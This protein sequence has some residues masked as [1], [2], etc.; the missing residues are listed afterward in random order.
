VC[1]VGPRLQSDTDLAGRVDLGG[2]LSFPVA[3]LD[4]VDNELN[5]IGRVGADV[6]KP[7]DSVVVVV[8]LLPGDVAA[9]EL[10]TCELVG[11]VL[12]RPCEVEGLRAIVLA[13]LACRF[14]AN[15]VASPQTPIAAGATTPTCAATTSPVMR[16]TI[17]GVRT[18]CPGHTDIGPG[19]VGAPVQR[20]HLPRSVLSA[21]ADHLAVSRIT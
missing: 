16:S 9:F 10:D 4:V 12:G 15:A 14:A 13:S 6:L 7:Q 17:V 18:T 5:L 19:S 3:L 8:A 20:T 21:V 1:L 11:S 2:R